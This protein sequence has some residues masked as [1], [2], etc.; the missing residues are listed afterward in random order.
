MYL[1]LGNL[2]VVFYLKRP[3]I[4]GWWLRWFLSSTVCKDELLIAVSYF[5]L[6]FECSVCSQIGTRTMLCN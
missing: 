4:L 6:K 2:L 3:F 5:Y 1:A